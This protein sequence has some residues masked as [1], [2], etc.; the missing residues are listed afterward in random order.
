LA[1]ESA[2]T[3]EE[4][5]RGAVVGFAVLAGAAFLAAALPAGFLDGFR[6]VTF[7][8]VAFLPVVRRAAFERPADLRF[9]FFL[10]TVVPPWS[11]RPFQVIR[12]SR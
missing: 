10:A 4:T 8:R 11:S 2:G 9:A 1:G 5:G 7:L 6:A 12:M 3:I